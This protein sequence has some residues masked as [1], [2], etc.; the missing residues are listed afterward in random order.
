MPTGALI[1]LAPPAGPP[2]TRRRGVPADAWAYRVRI[3]ASAI[4][5][6]GTA[7]V[8]AV[9]IVAR[10]EGNEGDAEISW[11][12]VR[13]RNHLAAIVKGEVLA[14]DPAATALPADVAPG[15]I[16]QAAF[17]GG[18]SPSGMTPTLGKS[19]SGPVRMLTFAVE[20]P[21][22][23][24]RPTPSAA[25]PGRQRLVFSI[26]FEWRSLIRGI[27]WRAMRTRTLAG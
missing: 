2:R 27:P 3:P 17:D 14:V 4:A 22:E 12:D 15:L 23:L 18:G 5:V 21:G 10:D 9:P 11:A 1:A 7:D 6:P 25:W 26:S 8:V 16:A 24:A 19:I 13:Q 20:K